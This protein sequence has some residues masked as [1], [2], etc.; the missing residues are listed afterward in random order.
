MTDTQSTTSPD[1]DRRARARSASTVAVAMRQNGTASPSRREVGE[2]DVLQRAEHEPARA[3][4]AVQR[5]AGAGVDEVGPAGDDPGLRPA[6]QL[7]AGERDERGAG[8]ERL[9]GG[10]LVAA[11]TA[12][13]RRAATGTA[14]SSRPD[15]RSTTTGGAERRQLARRMRPR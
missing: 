4:R 6:E 3:Q 14:A 11:A 2:R 8:V 9:A 7:V 1:A 13:G 15:P 5:V 10:G 12:A